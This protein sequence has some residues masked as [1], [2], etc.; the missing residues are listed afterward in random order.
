MQNL[1]SYSLKL[2]KKHNKAKLLL[3]K[4]FTTEYSCQDFHN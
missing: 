4:T 3:A 2:Q 1:S